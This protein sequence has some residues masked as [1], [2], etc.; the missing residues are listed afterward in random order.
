MI[1]RTMQDTKVRK[2]ESV[3]IVCITSNNQITLYESP[4]DLYDQL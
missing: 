2:E 4:H 3:W 1:P